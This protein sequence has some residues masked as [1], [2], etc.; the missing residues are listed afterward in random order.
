MLAKPTD[1]LPLA[2][3]LPGNCLYELKWDGF[4]Y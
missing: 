2:R 3:E 4:L 1:H